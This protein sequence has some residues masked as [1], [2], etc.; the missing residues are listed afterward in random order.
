MDLSLIVDGF[1]DGKQGGACSEVIERPGLGR[2]TGTCGLGSLDLAPLDERKA[3]SAEPHNDRRHAEL[4]KQRLSFNLPIVKE[5]NPL[6]MER[7]PR[8]PFLEENSVDNTW[9]S[10]M[11]AQLSKVWMGKTATR[12]TDHN[13]VTAG[14]SEGDDEYYKIEL[15]KRL[16][17]AKISCGNQFA[18]Q[19]CTRKFR[20]KSDL[21]RHLYAHLN[22]RPHACQICGKRFVQKGAAKIH[23]KTHNNQ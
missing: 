1:A 10:K 5:Q 17:T 9:Q 18:C 22:I 7:I 11:H 20:R 21:S 15:V 23:M 14:G 13:F 4:E 2:L 8:S 6:K 16:V 3:H 12:C 19:L